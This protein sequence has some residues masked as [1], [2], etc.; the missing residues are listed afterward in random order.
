MLTKT[1]KAFLLSML[2]FSSTFA[3]SLNSEIKLEEASSDS[4]KISWEAVEGAFCYSVYYDTIS[5]EDWEY[6]NQ[7]MCI[8]ENEYTLENLEATTSY[9]ISVGV[10]SEE[11]LEVWEKSQEISF[12]TLAVWETPFIAS[13]A[14]GESISLKIENTEVLNTTQLKLTFNLALD[15]N[16]QREFKVVNKQDSFV[17]LTVETSEV[18][19]NNEVIVTLLDEL[20]AST[21]YSLT[22][23]SLSW[24]NWENI[25]L[26]VDGLSD[27]IVPSDVTKKSEDSEESILVETTDDNELNDIELNSAW[28]EPN[29]NTVTTSQDTETLPTT[30]PGSA[31]LI[32]LAL[33][34]G[35][36]LIKFR[37]NKS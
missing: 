29:N 27:F 11:E 9:Y 13:S 31:L 7:E 25:E 32:L 21:E 16:A 35:I 19:W 14:Q 18:V 36:W 34:V 4:L 12:N 33:L 24:T 8:E 26:W 20:V 15:T 1:L 30:W 37:F 5:S 17:E 2:M 22:V 28:E 10:I 3:L 6:A 23:L